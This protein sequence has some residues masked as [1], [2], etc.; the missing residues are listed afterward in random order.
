MKILPENGAVLAER[1]KDPS[2]DVE[3][4]GVRYRKTALPLYKVIAVGGEGG[5][6]RPGDVIVCESTG[7]EA[8]LPDGR[9]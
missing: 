7:T 2:Q 3:E 4:G 9:T 1:V 5:E 8:K 6:W